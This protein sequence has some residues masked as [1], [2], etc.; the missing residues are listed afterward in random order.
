MQSNNNHIIQKQVLEVEME[1]PADAFQF[2]NRLGAVFHEKILPGLEILFDEIGS[3]NRLIRMDK[4]EIELGIVEAKNWENNL[5]EKAIQQIRQALLME[6]PVWHIPAKD[7]KIKNGHTPNSKAENINPTEESKEA[8]FME[9]FFFFLKTGMFPWYA[10]KQAT[11]NELLTNLLTKEAAWKFKEQLK[12]LDNIEIT[13]LIYQFDEQVLNV[14]IKHLLPLQKASFYNEFIEAI[15]FMKTHLIP[16]YKNTI[17]FKKACYLPFFKW[18]TGNDTIDLHTFYCGEMAALLQIEFSNMIHQPSFT[19]ILRKEKNT[20]LTKANELIAAP[21][22]STINKK[23]EILKDNQNENI[24]EALYIENAGLIL[25]HPFLQPF[26]WEI[27]FT[28]DDFFIDEYARMKAVLFTQH[29]VC[30]TTLFEEPELTLNK[31]LCGY[32][33]QEP[34]IRELEITTNEKAAATDLL[35]QVIKLW[36]KNNVQVN[37]TIEGFQQSFLQRPGKLVQKDSNWHLQVEQKPYDMLLASLPW[38]IGIIKTP[39]MDGML[40]V[41]WA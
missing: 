18:L 39:W 33:I 9:A 32:P 20:I 29:F 2:R 15:N 1:N 40:W 31:I 36:L 11:L 10:S 16:A 3:N 27:Q 23:N 35:Q 38:G 17:T 19:S 24:K 37:G 4:L 12:T 14:L 21:V 7:I 5:T 8:D 6:N 25:L 30:G 34:I 28:K 22:L 26:F 41:D 13:R